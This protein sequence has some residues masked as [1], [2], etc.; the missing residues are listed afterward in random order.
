M[1]YYS[2]A[3]SKAWDRITSLSPKIERMM[4]ETVNAALNRAEDFG[5]SAST[6]S[7]FT[8]LKLPERSPSSKPPNNHQPPN[9]IPP[10]NNH[11]PPKYHPPLNHLSDGLSAENRNYDSRRHNSPQDAKQRTSRS[12]GSSLSN[13]PSK[14]PHVIQYHSDR[15]KL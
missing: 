11:L 5:P 15:R 14:G 1:S 7:T 13:D 12:A 4:I 6:S 8:P 10:L 3:E 9:N 2:K